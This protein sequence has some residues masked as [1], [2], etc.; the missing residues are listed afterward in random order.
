M[1]NIRIRVQRYADW[2]RY[3]FELVLFNASLSSMPAGEPVSQVPSALFYYVIDSASTQWRM[4]VTWRQSISASICQTSSCSPVTV[5]CLLQIEVIG[6]RSRLYTF[7]TL[8]L[9]FAT[10]ISWLVLDKRA[11]LVSCL[12]WLAVLQWWSLLASLLCLYL[13]LDVDD[14]AAGGGGGG[15]GSDG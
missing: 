1:G 10:L 2:L 3:S 6:H 4:T 11:L 9:C 13:A 8:R 15:G 14:D 5:S 7:F 12:R